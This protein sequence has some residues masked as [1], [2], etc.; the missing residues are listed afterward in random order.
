[1]DILKEISVL[2]SQLVSLLHKM[3]VA[4]LSLR[5]IVQ[6]FSDKRVQIWSNRF[7]RLAKPFYC[8][9]LAHLGQNEGWSIFRMTFF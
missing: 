5:K 2:F 7:P 4:V 8:G 3:C 6:L 1:M 9:H